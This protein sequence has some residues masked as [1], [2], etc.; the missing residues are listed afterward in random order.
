MTALHHTGPMPAHGGSAPH[1][2][3]GVTPLQ[4]LSRFPQERP[5]AKKNQARLSPEDVE[6]KRREKADR[7]TAAKNAETRKRMASA[8]VEWDHR[9]AQGKRQFDITG[10]GKALRASLNHMN[11]CFRYKQDRTDARVLAWAK[12]DELFHRVHEGELPEPRFEPPVDRSG[13]PDVSVARLAAQQENA[14]L[15]SW[16]GRDMHGLLEMV[17]FHQR[18]FIDV[19]KGDVEESR[20]V[21]GIFKRALDQ[22]AAFYGVAP[23]NRFGGEVNH[24]LWK[25]EKR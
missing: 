9:T 14:R 23:D 1:P 22:A 16:L 19:A 3:T 11:Q 18:S 13:T 17:V 20:L 12:I 4:G 25:A 10:T 5:V 6:R 8:G 21:A 24:I 7:A 2:Y 15:K